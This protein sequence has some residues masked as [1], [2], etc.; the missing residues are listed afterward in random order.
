MGELVAECFLLDA[1]IGLPYATQSKAHKSGIPKE[2][3]ASASHATNGAAGMLSTT[4]LEAC[5]GGIPEELRAPT[6]NATTVVVL[7]PHRCQCCP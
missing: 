6:S 1:N 4:Q 2:I 7:A 5:E 3:Q